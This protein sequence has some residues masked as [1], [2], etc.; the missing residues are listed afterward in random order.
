MGTIVERVRQNGTTGYHAQI[1]IKRDGVVHREAR[2][3]DQR[4]TVAAW[5]KKPEAE[6][7][8]R[9]ALAQAKVEDPTLGRDPSTVVAADAADHCFRA[10]TPPSRR[11]ERAK[12]AA[13]SPW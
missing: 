5:I 6:L 2:I 3:F 13:I 8:A 9:G 10:L 1:V 4:A 7:D 11:R 12:R